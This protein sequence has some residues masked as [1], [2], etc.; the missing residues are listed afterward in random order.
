MKVLLAGATGALGTPLVRAL[1]AGGH[2]VLGLTRSPESQDH[3]SHLGARPVVANVMDRD[4]LLRAVKGL[5]AD[6]VIHALTALKK[7]PLRHRDMH[8][9]DALHDVGTTNLLAAAR[10]VGAYR[11]VAVRVSIRGG[12]SVPTTIGSSSIECEGCVLWL[13]MS[14][15]L[16]SRGILTVSG[17]TG[18][19][20]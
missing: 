7:T 11:F 13:T 1:I 5:Q 16:P 19:M 8:A 17:R 6:A 14:T 18:L 15:A 3:L 9:T 10:V 20:D 12:R 4:G 2:E